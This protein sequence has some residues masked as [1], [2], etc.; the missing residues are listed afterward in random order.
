[1]ADGMKMYFCIGCVVL[2]CQT[3]QQYYYNTVVQKCNLFIFLKNNSVK[4][5]LILIIFGAQ[6][7]EINPHH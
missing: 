2:H 3:R 7:P 4:N 5:R 6:N 1:M